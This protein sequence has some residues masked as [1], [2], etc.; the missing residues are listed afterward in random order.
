MASSLSIIL[1]LLVVVAT[2]TL[3]EIVPQAQNKMFAPHLRFVSQK[4]D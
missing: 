2:T 1:A 4:D 3:S